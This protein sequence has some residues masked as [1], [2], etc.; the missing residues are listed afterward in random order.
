M[1]K[2]VRNMTASLLACGIDVSKTMLFVQNQVPE[3]TEL[4]WILSSTQTIA[5]LQRLTQYKNKAG[6]YSSTKVPLGLI[7]Y[8]VLQAADVLLYKGTHVPVGDDQLQHFNLIGH[9]VDKINNH[10]KE[11]FFTRPVMVRLNSIYISLALDFISIS[12]N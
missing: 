6:M 10:I 4:S 8:P 7:N 5:R 11:D 9:F 2:D 1:N 12:S 3:H